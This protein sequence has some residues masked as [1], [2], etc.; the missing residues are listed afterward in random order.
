MSNTL[1]KYITTIDY[2]DKTLLILSGGSS[3]VSLC[4]FTTFIGTAVGI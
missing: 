2:A 4:S 3:D 1:N